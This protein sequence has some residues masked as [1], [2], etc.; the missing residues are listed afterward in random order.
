MNSSQFIQLSQDM[1][2]LLANVRQFAL[3]LY[4]HIHFCMR[5]FLKNILTL[6]VSPETGWQNIERETFQREDFLNRF[7][8][9]LMGLTALSAFLGFF[10]PDYSVA[11]AVRK[12]TILIVKYFVGFYLCL[13]LMKEIL[14]R[15]E[16]FFDEEDVQKIVGYLLSVLMFIEIVTNLLPSALSF[17]AFAPLYVIYLIWKS[18]K[19]MAVSQP[20]R[21]R[22]TIFMSAIFVSPYLLQYI[23]T[24]FM[25]KTI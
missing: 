1:T 17:L 11:F 9:P 18:N 12:A 25:P 20:N 19:Y 6:I 3:S 4:L 13:F 14:K 10:H 21:V 5:A 24:S 15:M 22:Y 23:L 8:F 16:I 7:L 2:G